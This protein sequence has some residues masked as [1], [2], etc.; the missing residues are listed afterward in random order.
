MQ[1]RT[2]K[3]LASA[4]LALGASLSTTAHAATIV[5]GSAQLIAAETDVSTNGTLVYAINFGGISSGAPVNTTV[6]GVTFNG[7]SA[8]SFGG[9]VFTVSGSTTSYTNNEYTGSSNPFGSLSANYKSL[10]NSNIRAANANGNAASF[11]LKLE[12]LSVGA[13]YAIQIWVNDSRD[14][15]AGGSAATGAFVSAG[16]AVELDFNSKTSGTGGVGQFVLGSFVADAIT[17]DIT[18]TSNTTGAGRALISALQLRQTAT[19]VPEPSAA[20]L[21]VGVCALAGVAVSRRRR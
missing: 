2:A 13:T 16:N 3:L 10:I 21:L 17:Q 14:V 19:P 18:I 15:S 6:N 1:T 4:A 9:G 12:Q 7:A 20:A 8:A 5:W 11:T